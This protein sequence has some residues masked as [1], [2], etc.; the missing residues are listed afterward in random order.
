MKD[1]P[2][3]NKPLAGVPSSLYLATMFVCSLSLTGEGLKEPYILVASEELIQIADLNGER[4]QV[5]VNSSILHKAAGI[6]F[7]AR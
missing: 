3:K 2:F 6:D 5:V 1:T 7:D 4:Q